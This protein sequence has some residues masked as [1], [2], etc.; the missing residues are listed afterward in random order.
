MIRIQNVFSN[1]DIEYIMNLNEV[2]D[3]RNEI[4]NKI[5]GSVYFN[6]LL[7]DSIKNTIKDKMNLDLSNIND[8]PMR[9]IKGDTIPHTDRGISHFDNT[10]LV[11]LSDSV[12]ELIVDSNSFPIVQN[13]AYIFNEG[14]NHETINTGNEPRLLLGPMSEN[15][16]AVGISEIIG[17]G[18][19]TISIRYTV[20]NGH[21]YSS[22]SDWI[23]FGFPVNVINTDTDAGFLKIVFVTDIELTNQLCYFNCTSDKIQFGSETLNNDGTR[24]IMTIRDVMNYNG[25]ILN[26]N[27]V[28][29]Y[30][31]IYIFNL[32]IVSVDSTLANLAGWICGN[33]YGTNAVNN[34]V[35]NCSS[36]GNMGY[37]GG[38]IVGSNAGING[39]LYIIGC[40]SSGSISDGAGGIIGN[41]AGINGGTINIESCWS[42]GIISGDDAGGIIGNNAAD[43]GTEIGTSVTI[44]YCYSTGNITG[45]NSGGICGSNPALHRGDL[46]I[47]NCYSSGDIASNSGGIIG[48]INNSDDNNMGTI[49]INNCYTAGDADTNNG[50][51]G[52]TGPHTNSPDVILLHCYTCGTV[53][54]DLGYFI[55]GSGDDIINTCYSEAYYSVSGW[56][57]SHASNVLIGLPLSGYVGTVWMSNTGNI[58]PP[59]LTNMGYNPYSAT[60]ITGTP[61]NLVRTDAFTVSK[62]NSTVAG[63]KTAYYAIIG[64]NDDIPDSFPTITINNSADG[65]ISTTSSTPNGTYTLKIYSTGSYNFT[66]VTLTV[67]DLPCLT[68]NTTVLTPNGYIDISKL[69]IGDNVIT[70]DNRIVEI[71]NIYKSRTI[72]NDKSY[73]CIVPKNSIGPNYPSETF[74][75]S[76]GHLIQYNNSSSIRWIYPR[77]YFKL[78]KSEK[79]IN[80]YHIKLE[81]YITDHLVI[82]NGVIVESLGDNSINNIKE[83][84]LRLRKTHLMVKYNNI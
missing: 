9:W 28:D 70:S 52:I 33:L 73:P 22:G 3:A 72:G 71:K 17:N 47:S 76:Q 54:G 49:T 83:S 68:D 34:Y 42:T 11:Y 12:G 66:T 50:A 7:T 36:D 32:N 5:S 79:V 2:V 48:S 74:K 37:S 1:E 45:I 51:G 40:S 23:T 25:F 35:I 55:G 30:N 16:F 6:V 69:S 43:N 26:N 20:E 63:V 39:E 15:G 27:G 56:N 58:Q 82:N 46:T 10:Y 60:N 80:Y 44:T 62:G 81:N 29:G 77:K 19:T 4:N 84:K 21:Q 24:P 57:F 31:N 65:I 8:I 78:D 61:P 13:N 59:E 18:G 67:G 41:Q 53:S 75:I 38:G 14:L 64:I